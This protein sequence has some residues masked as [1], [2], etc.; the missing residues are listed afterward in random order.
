MTWLIKIKWGKHWPCGENWL[1][2]T[3]C[4]SLMG[5]YFFPLLAV[6]DCILISSWWSLPVNAVECSLYSIKPGACWPP[7]D[8][9]ELLKSCR[10]PETSFYK[11]TSEKVF[12]KSEWVFVTAQ[13]LRERWA[14][15]LLSQIT[16]HVRSV[17]RRVTAPATSSASNWLRLYKNACPKDE[18][19]KRSV[20]A[21]VFLATL[22]RWDKL[23]C[24]NS[25]LSGEAQGLQGSQDALMYW[26]GANRAASSL[27]LN[28]KKMMKMQ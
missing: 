18:G 17:S 6:L 14:S 2:E 15:C 4:W 16:T 27:K 26:K 9:A 5:F 23:E 25:T 1:T 13:W 21:A 12:S 28:A 24:I 19:I 10:C 11:N 7:C 3:K 20:S 8:K 22:K